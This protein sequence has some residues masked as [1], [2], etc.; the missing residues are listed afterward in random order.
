MRDARL[1]WTHAHTLRKGSAGSRASDR[2]PRLRAGTPPS[3][4]GGL[5]ADYF[6]PLDDPRELSGS[7]LPGIVAHGLFAPETVDQ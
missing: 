6:G 1:G 3:P 7:T 2:A 4:D 5:I